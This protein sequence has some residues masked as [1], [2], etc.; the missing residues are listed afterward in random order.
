M[1]V[2]IDPRVAFCSI[3]AVTLLAG[4]DDSSSKKG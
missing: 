2:Q 1:K 4:C 3:V